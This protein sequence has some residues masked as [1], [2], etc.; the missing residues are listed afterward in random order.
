MYPPSPPR[1][2]SRRPAVVP[3]STG[4]TTSNNCSP[5]GYRTFPRPNAATPGSRKQTERPRF[6]SISASAAARSSA[7]RATWRRRI[8]II[9]T[10]VPPAPRGRTVREGH[11]PVTCRIP[12]SG[13]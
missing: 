6:A 1:L 4:D 3:A 7:T 5:T 13:R 10:L 2:A 8:R 9:A 12:E 11:S